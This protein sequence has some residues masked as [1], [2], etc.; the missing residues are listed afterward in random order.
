MQVHVIDPDATR[1]AEISR[2]ILQIGQHVEIYENP[3]EYL[4]WRA[5]SGYI[6]AFEGRDYRPLQQLIAGGELPTPS[7]PVA[8]YS[9]EPDV[10]RVVEALLAGAVGYLIWPLNRE[11]FEEELRAVAERAELRR[12]K[13]E[14]IDQAQ[15][16]VGELSN[17][18]TEVLSCLT[19][20]LSNKEIARNLGIS[21]RTVEIHRANM[22]AKISASSTAD[23]VRTGVYAGLDE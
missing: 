21:P 19:N 7:L 12:Q 4:S 2:R 9:D 13:T 15:G 11:Q 1:R 10:E 18:E 6:L 22:F 3:E 8:M 16:V 20:G 14:K 5:R 23:A 17:R